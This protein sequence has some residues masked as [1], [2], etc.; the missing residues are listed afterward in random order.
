[1]QVIEVL[2][3]EESK[4]RE[5]RRPGLS[6]AF[7]IQEVSLLSAAPISYKLPIQVTSEG[8]PGL[9]RLAQN[10]YGCRVLQKLLQESPPHLDVAAP[11]APL[12]KGRIAE[13][14]CHQYGNYV[15]RM[16]PLSLAGGD[17]EAV[18]A[19]IQYVIAHGRAGVVGEVVGELEGRIVG[20]STD[21][22]ASHVVEKA[23]THAGR[24]Q[25]RRLIQEMLDSAA[26]AKGLSGPPAATTALEACLI[27][28]YANYVVQVSLPL[29]LH[30]WVWKKA[31]DGDDDDDD[32]DL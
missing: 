15:V 7:V 14:A 3:E 2:V 16:P 9:L 8:A 23:V 6:L 20:L 17:G 28:Q 12:L 11:L 18:G 19:Q 29:P 13:L 26:P 24:A 30:D 22:H 4:P 1:M 10:V 27:D 31:R 21:E 32:R 5:D 25:Q